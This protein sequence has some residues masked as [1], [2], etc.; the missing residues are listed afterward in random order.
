MVTWQLREP[1]FQGAGSYK[2][3]PISAEVDGAGYFETD[4]VVDFAL[5]VFA[6]P[7]NSAPNRTVGYSPV[8]QT[9]S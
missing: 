4:D 1:F 6:K 8:A 5:G 9:G 2:F 7:V 3:G